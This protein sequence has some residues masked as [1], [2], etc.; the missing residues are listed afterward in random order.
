MNRFL[1]GQIR[2]GLWRLKTAHFIRNKTQLYHIQLQLVSWDPYF[3]DELREEET[4]NIGVWRHFINGP[5]AA[6]DMKVNL[7]SKG[8]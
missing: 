8:K 3:R 7:C 5:A 4:V 6:A 1:Q 2:D